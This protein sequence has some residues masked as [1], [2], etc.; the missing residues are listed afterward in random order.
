MAVALPPV[1]A[2]VATQLADR[3]RHHIALRMLPFL[4]ALYIANY[5]DRTSVAYAAIGMARELG[6]SDK[7]N[8]CTSMTSPG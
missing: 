8:L 5:L 3:T 1:L 2:P 7:Y 4:F 6:F